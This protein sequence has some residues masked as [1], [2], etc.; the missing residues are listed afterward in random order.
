MKRVLLSSLVAVTF[1]FAHHHHDH[2]TNLINEFDPKS[3]DHI[4]VEMNLLG[5]D[6][7][8]KVGEV[9]AINTNYGVALFPNM[10]GLDAHGLYGFHVH[11]NPDCG[12][13]EKGLGMKAGGH[14]DPKN[15]GKH[16]F[17]WDDEGHKG[18]LPAIYVN[19]DG[20]ANY[21]VLAPKIKNIDE[22]KGHS[23]MIHVGGDNHS[24][25]PAALGGGGARMICGVIK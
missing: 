12:A 17:P 3:V 7:D 22:L 2:D 23:L 5:K 20:I 25:K 16:S 18:D 6:G 24:D 10:S 8:K 9:V 15:S 14:W 1:A 21:P 4:V 19:A 11:T 13:T